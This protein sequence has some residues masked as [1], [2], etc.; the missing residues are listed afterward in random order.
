[1]NV[2]N[3]LNYLGLDLDN[4]PEFIKEFKELDYRPSRFNNE[5][6][7]KIYR[8]ININEIQILLTHTNRMSDTIQKYRK[9]N[10]SLRI[11]NTR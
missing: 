4:I 3:K 8:Y 2:I 11:F 10:T 5:H 9:G 7:Y 1:M 6:L